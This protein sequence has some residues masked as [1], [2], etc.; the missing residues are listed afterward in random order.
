VPPYITFA[1]EPKNSE[2]GSRINGVVVLEVKVGADGSVEDI[3]LLNAP[4]ADLAEAA[5]RTVKTWRY[6]PAD[7][8]GV[9]VPAIAHLEIRFRACCDE[10]V[11]MYPPKQPTA[12]LGQYAMLK[13]GPCAS[14]VRQ[15]APGTVPP[16]PIYRREPQ[17]TDA[18]RK[19]KLNGEVGL[20]LKIDTAGFVED[21]CVAKSL[22]ADLDESAASTLKNWRFEPAR[23]DGAPVPYVT[24]VEVSFKL[25]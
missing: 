15:P 8:S 12:Q 13:N 22:P 1:P 11:L 24:Y 21:V 16:R 4:R 7:R 5:M 10:A 20:V 17:Y 19:M 6:E 18:A 23:K 14:W 3:C 9:K 25:Y 2:G